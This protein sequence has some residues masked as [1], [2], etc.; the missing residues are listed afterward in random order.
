MELL[1]HYSFVIAAIFLV[2]LVGGVTQWLG[3]GRNALVVLLGM[4]LGA[5]L[6]W[7]FV[8]PSP[9]QPSSAA[10]VRAQIGAGAPVLLEFQ[11][12]Y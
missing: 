1:N 6:V 11:S 9:G 5:G 2:S 4:A 12:P 7:L 10:G 3:G 8:R